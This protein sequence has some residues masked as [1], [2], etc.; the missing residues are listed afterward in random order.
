[1]IIAKTI[2]L[3][4]RARGRCLLFALALCLGSVDAFAAQHDSGG[5]ISSDAAA[6]IVRNHSGG[7]ILA[8]KPANSRKADVY[9]VREQ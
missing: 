4:G 9:R 8:V 7:R 3:P 2:E 5:G 1:M 6:A